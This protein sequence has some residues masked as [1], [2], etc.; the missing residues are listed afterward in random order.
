MKDPGLFPLPSAD[1]LDGLAKLPF[2]LRDVYPLKAKHRALLPA[3]I[4]RL[5]DFLTSDRENLPRDYMTRPEFLSAYLHYFLPWNI[6][7]QGR[8]LTGLE[9]ALKPGARV[10]DLGAGPL[11]FLQA[12]W[13]SR[14]GLRDQELEYLA[15]NLKLQGRDA[16]AA[17]AAARAVELT[18]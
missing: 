16:E 14:P 18:K 17:E 5:S 2:I 7:R 9:F 1:L 3:G 4:R 11:T 12:L 15:A 6:Y 10:V 8:L 13:L